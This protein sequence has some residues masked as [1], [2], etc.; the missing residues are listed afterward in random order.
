MFSETF[1]NTLAEFKRTR[2]TVFA[3]K[4]FRAHLNIQ[5]CFLLLF[6]ISYFVICHLRIHILSLQ[7]GVC[8]FVAALI[9][10]FY[11]AGFAWMLFEGVYLYLMVVKVY[12]TVVRMRLFYAVA[13]GE[14]Y[15]WK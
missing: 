11:L 10:Y 4:T 1:G 12:N 14:C 2:K 13:W 15:A 8:V 3:S 9:H 7:Q 5:S 6:L